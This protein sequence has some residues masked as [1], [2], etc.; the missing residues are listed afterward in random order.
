MKPLSPY[1]EAKTKMVE[2]IRDFREKHGQSWHIAYLFNHESELRKSHFLMKK[3]AHYCNNYSNKSG[4]LQLGDISIQRDFGLAKDYVH[5]FTKFFETSNIL[6][7]VIC[8]GHTRPLKDLLVDFFRHY[9]ID[10]DKA[11]STNSYNDRPNDIPMNFG[12]PTEQVKKL[13]W[14]PN[15]MGDKVAY[16]LAKDY[17][18]FYHWKVLRDDL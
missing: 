9:Q 14:Q 8:T 1:A 5:S 10:F 18:N 12:D 7:S 16:A 6:D 4:K 15:Y 3:V 2:I 17:K 13:N 11:V